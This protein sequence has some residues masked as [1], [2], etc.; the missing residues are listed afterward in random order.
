MKTT[1]SH[2]P[3]ETE[4]VETARTY[5]VASQPTESIARKHDM[6]FQTQGTSLGD[7]AAVI[8]SISLLPPRLQVTGNN[9][10]GCKS[11]LL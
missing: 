5:V 2:V 7:Q 10:L 6:T 9:R 3:Q 1:V 8:F 4:A 11:V